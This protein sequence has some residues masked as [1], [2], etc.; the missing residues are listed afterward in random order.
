MIKRRNFLM[1]IVMFIFTFIGMNGVNAAKGLYCI[2][3]DS[4]GED[5]AMIVQDTFGNH[6][7]YERDSEGVIDTYI[8]YD[9]FGW[10]LFDTNDGNDVFGSFDSCMEKINKGGFFDTDQKLKKSG[11]V[12]DDVK[13]DSFSF[14]SVNGDVGSIY[15]E[16]YSKKALNTWLIQPSDDNIQHCLYAKSSTSDDQKTTAFFAIQLDINYT[17]KKV[18]ASA[19][20]ANYKSGTLSLEYTFKDINSNYKYSDLEKYFKNSCPIELYAAI[21]L[22]PNGSQKLYFSNIDKLSYMHLKEEK[23]LWKFSNNGHTLTSI[24]LANYYPEG[25]VDTSIAIKPNTI[26]IENCE[27]VFGEDLLKILHDGVNAIKIMIP[28]LLIGLGILDFA[29]AVFGGSEDNMKKSAVKFGKRVLIGIVIFFIPS[30][31]NI[32]L[33]IANKIWGNIDPSLCGIL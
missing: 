25:S 24:G 27:D 7:F 5:Y 32:I 2:Y 26:T 29:K 19:K 28:L 10:T 3:D 21:D 18:V 6:S 30:I 11:T 4:L 12:L 23:R 16:S 1:F 31:L 15:P 20:G 22:L 33:D 13:S 14:F 17:T 9:T 8:D